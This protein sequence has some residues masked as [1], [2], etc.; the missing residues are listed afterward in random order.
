M[1]CGGERRGCILPIVVVFGGFGVGLV[2]RERLVIKIKTREE[3]DVQR[4]TLSVFLVNLLRTVMRTK[5]GHLQRNSLFGE[6]YGAVTPE[7]A[8]KK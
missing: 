5:N 2:V 8:G 7:N 1:A 3:R 6:T 4:L